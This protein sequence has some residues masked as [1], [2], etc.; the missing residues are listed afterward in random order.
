[1]PPLFAE[2]LAHAIL[3]GVLDGCADELR[4]APPSACSARNVTVRDGAVLLADADTVELHAR[5]GGLGSP[6]SS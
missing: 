2:H 4:C 1:M 5:T 3:R 6:A